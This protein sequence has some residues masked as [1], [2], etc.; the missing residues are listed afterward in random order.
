MQRTAF[1]VGLRLQAIL[2]IPSVSS[3]SRSLWNKHYQLA[4]RHNPENQ[5]TLIFEV[6]FN[7][8]RR[9]LYLAELHSC[10]L[11]T[12]A[13]ADVLRLQI[14]CHQSRIQGGGRLERSYR[15]KPTKVTL[16]TILF[17]NSENNISKPIPNKCFV[18][19]AMSHCSR[20]KAIMSSIALSQQ[21]CEVYFISQ[22]KPLWDLTNK[23]YR[24][25]PSP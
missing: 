10:K 22:A 14:R 9:N 5:T 8:T 6:H 15:L 21:C 16:F 1:C 19:F 11:L 17:Y 4:R 25:R 24:N 18:M 2:G 3:L 13:L 12:T 7:D 23:S 20:Y